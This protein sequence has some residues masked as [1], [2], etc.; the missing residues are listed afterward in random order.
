MKNI[1]GDIIYIEATKSEMENLVKLYQVG[2]IPK[3]I[4]RYA[5]MTIAQALMFIRMARTGS[6]RYL[7]EGEVKSFNVSNIAS[8]N[9]VKNDIENEWVSEDIYGGT[10][11]AFPEFKVLWQNEM[12]I[13]EYLTFKK[14]G[15]GINEKTIHRHNKQLKVSRS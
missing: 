7:S 1:E 15:N 10:L 8:Q 4:A 13:K 14:D 3:T 12:T 11:G 2:A 5:N 6:I 9:Y